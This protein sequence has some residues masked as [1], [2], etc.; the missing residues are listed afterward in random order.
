MIVGD[1]QFHTVKPARFEPA[2]EVAPTRT[3]F[4]I[5]QLDAENLAAAVPVDTDSNQHRLTDNHAGFAHA[6]VPS[7]HNQVGKGFVQ[8]PRGELGQAVVQAFIDRADRRG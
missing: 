1:D 8:R 2:Q 5:G 3:A 6:L 4:P 7:I